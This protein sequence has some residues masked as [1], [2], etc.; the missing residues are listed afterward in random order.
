MHRDFD[1]VRR[2][3]GGEEREL[4]TFTLAGETFMVLPDPTL[5]DTF[6]L[7]DA[8]EIPENFD[9]TRSQDMQLVRLLSKFIRKMLPVEERPRYDQALYKVPTSH[10]VVIIEIASYIAEHVIVPGVEIANPVLPP[11]TF[12]RGRRTTGHSSKSKSGGR[13]RSS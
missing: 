11:T 5:G 8:P 3:Y 4:V 13:N 1:A 12:S 6:D 7:A 10:T 9:P 2:A